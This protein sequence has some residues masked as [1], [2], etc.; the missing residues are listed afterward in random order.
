[1]GTRIGSYRRR[2]AAG[3]AS[4]AAGLLAIAGIACSDA[5]EAPTVPRVPPHVSAALK[6][7]RIGAGLPSGFRFTGVEHNRLTLLTLATLRPESRGFREPS[8]RCAAILR[9]LNTQAPRT[10]AAAGVPALAPEVRLAISEALR[11]LPGCHP[12]PFVHTKSTANLS[13]DSTLAI[14]P[15][16]TS[17][18]SDQAFVVM[19]AALSRIAS[20]TSFSAV[21]E[22][23]AD[24]TASAALLD[25]VS[26]AAVYAM[27][28]QAQ[29]SYVLWEPTGA[30]WE[31][32][33]PS[34]DYQS[35]LRARLWQLPLI[36]AGI[37]VLS[38]DVAGCIAA[39]RVF[40]TLPVIQ[41]PRLVGA[42]CAA[43]AAA[44][45]LYAGYKLMT[46]HL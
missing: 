33:A 30:G 37:A 24:A 5:R 21:S 36:D 39:M 6:D 19:D 15:A 1:M 27:I 10:A 25:D 28:S 4:L 18:I 16:D 11:P 8:V 32:L 20:A 14:L 3:F 13:V 41:D 43:G 40:R 9:V 17:F 23:F 42:V 44:G 7:P 34:G 12:S 45:T 22:A 46:A 31:E 35:I 29:G 38:A 26:A 2:A